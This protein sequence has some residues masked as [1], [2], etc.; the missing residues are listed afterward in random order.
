MMTMPREAERLTPEQMQ[1]QSVADFREFVRRLKETVPFYREKLAGVDPKSL[2]QVQDI[3]DLPVTTKGDLRDAYPFDMLGVDLAR[4]QEMHATSGTTGSCVVSA[5]TDNDLRLWRRAMGRVFARAGVGSADVVHN[6]YGYGLFTGGLGM[7]YAALE[8]GAAVVP[9]SGGYTQRQVAMLRDLGATVICATPSYAQHIA[10][11]M[12]EMNVTADALRL[13]V[14]IFGAEPWSLE[15]CRELERVFN[16]AALDVYGL[17][18]IIGPGVASECVQGHEGLHVS[19]DLFYFEV[20]NPQTGRPVADGERGELVLSSILREATPVMRYRTGDITQ[21]LPEP[22]PC[23]RTTRRIDHIQGRVDDMFTLRGVNLFPREIEA[24][25]LQMD[26]LAPVFQLVLDRQAALDR[27]DVHVEPRHPQAAHESLAR[28][29]KEQLNRALGVNVQVT[30]KE[31]HSIPRSEGKAI[32]LV[33][34]RKLA[35]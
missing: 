22:C 7:H 34:R 8:V 4:V 13:R 18:E 31:P 9:M 29:V 28:H 6:A 23:G 12:E 19:E 5:Y 20:I 35:R 30:V 14:G 21:V 25:L 16:I 1:A 2:Q 10:E 27:L 11:T 24:A 17:A 3:A 26:E 33:D 32:R 15:M